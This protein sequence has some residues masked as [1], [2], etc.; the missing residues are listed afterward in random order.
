MDSPFVSLV[1]M[2]YNCEKYVEQALEGA[3]SQD[4]EN[5][6]IIIS[7][8]ASS[9][10]TVKKIKEYLSKYTGNKSYR[11]LIND[12]NL[13]LG[14][15]LNKLW[16]KEAKGAWIVPSAGDDI[17]FANRTSEMMKKAADDV[18]LIHARHIGINEDNKEIE[19]QNKNELRAVKKQI[20]DR[21][22]PIEFIEKNICVHGNCMAINKKMLSY[23]GP[24]SEGVVNEDVVLAY[25]SVMYSRIV[26]IDY[27]L[28]YYRIHSES[29]S[30]TSANSIKFKNWADYKKDIQLKTKR[31]RALIN[32]ILKDTQKEGIAIE[33]SKIFQ[34]RIKTTDIH[35][36]LYLEGT[37]LFNFLLS[38]SFYKE[39]IKR[40][41]FP[42]RYKFQINKA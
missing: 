5:M 20:F 21:A 35:E 12:K 19:R 15:H 30:Y 37:F 33:Q 4:Y 11:L 22:D 41:T 14:E 27:P 18:A 32:Q 42:I 3:F 13:G 1:I 39:L 2:T 16:W 38:I 25:R 31:R 10:E 17:S 24:F 29:I 9:D 8:D 7:D 40:I 36:F 34:S 23:F 28:V 26:L 6:E